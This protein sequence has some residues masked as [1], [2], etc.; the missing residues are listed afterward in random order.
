MGGVLYM[1][2]PGKKRCRFLVKII[3][4]EE[5]SPEEQIKPTPTARVG[6]SLTVKFI[7]LQFLVNREAAG[8]HKT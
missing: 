7:F 5:E 2:E 3:R 8:K 6:W 1:T 4:T